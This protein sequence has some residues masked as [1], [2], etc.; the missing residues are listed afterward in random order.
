MVCIK[1]G[2]F[3]RIDS[4]IIH[5]GGKIDILWKVDENGDFLLGGETEIETLSASHSIIIGEE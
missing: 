3:P 4:I 2:A 1:S 5:E